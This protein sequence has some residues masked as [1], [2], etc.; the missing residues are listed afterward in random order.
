M[1]F[2]LGDSVRIVTR[3][4]TPAD[5]KSGTFYPF[6]CGLCGTIDR[7]YDEEVCVLVDLD[8]LP[9][10]MLKRHHS[11]QDSMKKKW[12]DGL[13][14][15][16]RNRL[17]AEDKRFD[18]AYTLLVQSADLEKAEGVTAAIKGTIPA[19]T[20]STPVSSKDLDA[21]EEAYLEARK[22]ELEKA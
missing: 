16:A 1:K 22:K 8:S 12:L 3:E 5:V 21:N 11:I 13:S 4:Q 2:K 14:N 17:S 10:D 20:S 9:E 18:L 15:E 7:I 19:L 6:Y